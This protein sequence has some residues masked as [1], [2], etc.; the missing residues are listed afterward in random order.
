MSVAW[1]WVR[2]RN[3]YYNLHE[4]HA[5]PDFLWVIIFDLP[6]RTVYYSSGTI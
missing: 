6:G 1:W 2:L 4:M 5:L 3:Q